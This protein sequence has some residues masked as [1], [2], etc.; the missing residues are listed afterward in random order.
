MSCPFAL[1]TFACHLCV[2]LFAR[3][4]CGARARVPDMYN[5]AKMGLWGCLRGGGCRGVTTR[6][7][8]RAL[9]Y[10]VARRVQESFAKASFRSWKLPQGS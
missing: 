7:D 6:E 4:A 5:N 2:L 3:S 1:G 8:P 10:Q 9:R